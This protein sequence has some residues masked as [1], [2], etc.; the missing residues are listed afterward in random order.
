MEVALQKMTS[1]IQLSFIPEYRKYV[2]LGSLGTKPNM[3]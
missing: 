3:L 1:V 2:G